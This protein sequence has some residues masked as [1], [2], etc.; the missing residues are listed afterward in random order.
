MGRKMKYI[1]IIF[2][3]LIILI[4]FTG[5]TTDN[6]IDNTMENIVNSSKELY[7]IPVYN[8]KT[9]TLIPVYK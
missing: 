7:L 1:F 6:N 9:I 8:G 3:L 5:C 4:T 2:I